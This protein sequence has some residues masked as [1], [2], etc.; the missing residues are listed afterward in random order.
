MK[1]INMGGMKSK[2]DSLINSDDFGSPAN[3]DTLIKLINIDKD[4]SIKSYLKNNFVDIEE[5]MGD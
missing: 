4:G 2:L 5:L 3:I 1:T